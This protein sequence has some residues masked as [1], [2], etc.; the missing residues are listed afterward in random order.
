MG[1]PAT[2][3]V[4]RTRGAEFAGGSL[5]KGEHPVRRDNQSGVREG[6][7]DKTK[8]TFVERK[9]AGHLLNGAGS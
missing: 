5:G 1:K 4:R 9:R 3:K 7:Q 2:C 6:D 8:R